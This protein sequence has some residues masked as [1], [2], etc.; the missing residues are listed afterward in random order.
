MP[1]TAKKFEASRAEMC[2]SG[3]R[4]V[5]YVLTT[6]ELARMIKMTG[7]DFTDCNRFT[8]LKRLTTKALPS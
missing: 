8:R 5:D 4:D 7:I 1:C 6:R 3:Y 2:D